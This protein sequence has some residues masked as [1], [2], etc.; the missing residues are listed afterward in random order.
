MEKMVVVLKKQTVHHSGQK[1]AET[2]G[3]ALQIDYKFS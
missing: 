2:D 3:Y 1:V